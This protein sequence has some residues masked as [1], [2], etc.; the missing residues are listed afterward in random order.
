MIDGYNGVLI[1]VSPETLEAAI[2]YL[3]LNPEYGETLGR[4]ALET[5]LAFSLERWKER[6]RAA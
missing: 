4:R 1:N 5:S 3:V 6:W 2:E